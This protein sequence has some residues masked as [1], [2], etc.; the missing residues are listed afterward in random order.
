MNEI[1]QYKEFFEDIRQ[2]DSHGEHWLARKLMPGLGYEKW[3]RFVDSIERAIAAASNSGVDPD[4]HFSRR[5]E[6]FGS[7]G[8]A[9][10][11]Y[12][13]TRYAAYLLAMNG[14]PRKPEI[15][16][17][18]TY[19]AV[20]TREAETQVPQTYAAALRTAADY[21]DRAER[22]EADLA[23][24]QPKANSWDTLAASRG[25][26]SV[27]DAA[28]ILSR[29]P[30]ITVGRDQLF[31]ELRG[32]GWIYRQRNDGRWRS[33]QSQINN[34]RLSEL[35]QYYENSRSGELTLSAPQVRVAV[36]GLHELHKRFGG[37]ARL[38]L[39][40]QLSLIHG[41]NS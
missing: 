41:G 5:R 6:S 18:Q 36:K 14:D 23:E 24:A 15:A 19:F 38:Q 2:E 33:Y 35:P 12:R 4:Q 16:A 22:A 40:T 26:F 7:R 34:G 32:I 3:E 10:V 30:A 29:D 17:A 37:T 1:Q 39:D 21:A 13:L 9:A 31:Q 11:D 28:K 20:R 8:P 27:A 25:D